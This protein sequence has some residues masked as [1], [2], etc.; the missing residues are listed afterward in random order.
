MEPVAHFGLGSETAV[1][2]VRVAWPDGRERL[3]DVS[4]VDQEVVAAHPDA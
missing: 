3:L 4:A 2:E 1:E